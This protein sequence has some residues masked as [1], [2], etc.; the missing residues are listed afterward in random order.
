MTNDRMPVLVW[1]P[2]VRHACSV[3]EENDDANFEKVEP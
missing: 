2:I 1:I 3:R